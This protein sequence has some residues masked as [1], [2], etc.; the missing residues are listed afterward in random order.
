MQT[1]MTT[2]SSKRQIVIPAS[3]KMP[4]KQ[5]DKLLIYA[6]EENLIM[7]KPESIKQLHEDLKFAK[8]TEE[9]IRR[10]QAGKGTIMETEDFLKMLRKWAE[11]GSTKSLKK[12]TRKS[13]TKKSKTKSLNK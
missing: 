3:L 1:A 13:R 8:K 2:I 10:M 5:G 6:D 4:F 7:R 12:S 11:S 9:S